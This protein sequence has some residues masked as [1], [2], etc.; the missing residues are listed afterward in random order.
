[1]GAVPCRFLLPAGHD[2]DGPFPGGAAWE[3][4]DKMAASAIKKEETH[5][6]DMSSSGWCTQC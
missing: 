1:M 2:G 5:W 4:H 6:L 3:N